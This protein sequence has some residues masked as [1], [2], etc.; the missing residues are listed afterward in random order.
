[1]E[2]LSP[3][4]IMWN[5]LN[6][7]ETRSTVRPPGKGHAPP[8]CSGLRGKQK[9]TSR[10]HHIP[11]KTQEIIGPSF[12]VSQG[13]PRW[14]AVRTLPS[15][16]GSV[17]LIPGQGAKILRVLLPPHKKTETRYKTETVS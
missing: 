10:K 11:S 12:E 16:G 17:R 9:D 2:L 13:R 5:K 1:M 8:Q 14:F 7:G 15:K 4:A 6:S 3:T